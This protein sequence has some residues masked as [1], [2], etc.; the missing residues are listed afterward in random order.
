MVQCTFKIKGSIELTC[1]RS[2]EDFDFLIDKE[3]KIIFRYADNYEE[4]SEDLI[5]IP[6]GQIELDLA[7]FIYE[8]IAVSI[9]MK[10][11]HPKFENETSEDDEEEVEFIYSSEG[12]NPEENKKDDDDI[13]PRWKDLLNLK[14]N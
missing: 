3:E 7:P 14:N 12:E 8:L 2:L 1:D 10:K 11:L 9:P 5:N 4:L 13:D 6:H